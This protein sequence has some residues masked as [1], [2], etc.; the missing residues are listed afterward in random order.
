[1]KRKLI[2]TLDTC[3][4]IEIPSG[5]KNL[6]PKGTKVW[7]KQALGGSLTI[8]T[9]R[10][11]LSRLDK[12]NFKILGEENIKEA[13]SNVEQHYK[14]LKK[15]S[16]EDQVWEQLKTIYDPEIPVDIVSL[17]LVYECQCFESKSKKDKKDV[18]IKM[19]LT[20]PTC[21]MGPVLQADVKER[22]EELE[23]IQDVEVEL[24]F[25]PIWNREMMSE[26]ARLEL[27]ML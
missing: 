15:L 13:L 26:E 8:S 3:E 23:G 16:L 10:G 22:V 5:N 17:G 24:V 2:S 1:M 20:S 9:E 14:S 7:I 6:L 25:S 11:Y 27:N 21:G 12:E 19:T 4:V 18:F